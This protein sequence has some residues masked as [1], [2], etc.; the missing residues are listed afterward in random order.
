MSPASFGM[1]QNNGW[2]RYMSELISNQK[3]KVPEGSNQ[4]RKVPE[5]IDTSDLQYLEYGDVV[6]V[7]AE[8]KKT[9][10]HVS[11]VKN[12]KVYNVKILSALLKKAR[13]NKNSL[14]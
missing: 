2:K 1:A 6:R 3:R 14:L 13:L 9:A 10:D 11:R 7:S 5:G 4:K 8:V 12:L